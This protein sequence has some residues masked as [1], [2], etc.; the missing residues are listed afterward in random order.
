ML[1]VTSPR[2]APGITLRPDRT[3]T[4]ATVTPAGRPAVSAAPADGLTEIRLH[5]VPAAGAVVELVTG[6]GPLGVVVA[7]LSPG[8]NRVPGFV[9]RP[10]EL[11]GAPD[12]TSDQVVLAT[13]VELSG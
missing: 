3:V 13:R 9:P 7:D 12:P 8:L 5:A 6:P 1:R 2:G 10:P 4:A 11:R